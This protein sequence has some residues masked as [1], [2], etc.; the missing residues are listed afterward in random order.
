[1]YPSTLNTWES[2]ALK[3]ELTKDT[4]VAAWLRNP[5][6]KPWSLC[7]PYKANGGWAPLYPDLLVVRRAG[8]EMVIDIVDPHALDLAD[9]P[10]KA[11]GLAE[12]ASKHAD[13]FGRI[14]LVICKGEKMLTLDLA[15]EAVRDKVKGVQTAAH[16]RQLYEGGIG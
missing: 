3:A 13:S 2:K 8:K 15:D 5:P 9:A 7:V 1:M 14:L 12:Y 10:A 4:E 6:R 11:A 16:L